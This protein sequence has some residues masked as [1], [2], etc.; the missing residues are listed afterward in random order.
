[1]E[2]LYRKKTIHSVPVFYNH[3]AIKFRFNNN[4]KFIAIENKKA[5]SIIASFFHSRNIL[6][7]QFFGGLS[8]TFRTSKESL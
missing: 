7:A 3:F 4:R 8:N 2:P 1:M 5:S 6:A